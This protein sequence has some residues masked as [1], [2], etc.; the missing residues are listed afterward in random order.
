MPAKINMFL[1]NGNLNMN[2][3]IMRSPV[4]SLNLAVVSDTKSATPSSASSSLNKS[5]IS[6]IHNVK[7]G[8]GSC[9]RK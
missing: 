5:I 6:R 9:G 1:S 3:N 7:P 8:C 2:L 4:N